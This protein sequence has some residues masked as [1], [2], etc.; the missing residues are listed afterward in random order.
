[1]DPMGQVSRQQLRLMSARRISQLVLCNKAHQR[2]APRALVSQLQRPEAKDPVSAGLVP[3]DTIV[4]ALF[5]A[6]ISCVFMLSSL[7]R[8]LFPDFSPGEDASQAGP[9][10]NSS[11]PNVCKVQFPT[12]ITLSFTRVRTSA[13]WGGVWETVRLVAGGRGWPPPYRLARGLWLSHR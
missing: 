6:V 2:Q 5:T 13:P 7:H 8:C 11:Q 4:Y 3:P 10:T 1:V 9:P 12:K